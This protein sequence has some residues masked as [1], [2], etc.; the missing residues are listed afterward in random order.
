[1]LPNGLRGLRL[2]LSTLTW[3]GGAL[4]AVLVT[5]IALR[6]WIYL[7]VLGR[8]NSD[9]SVVGLMVLHAMRGDFSTFFWGSAYG[10]PQEVL[11]SVPVFAV[12]REWLPRACGSSRSR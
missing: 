2:R 9:E 10:G 8:P 4:A 3:W 5:G 1:M 6:V 11:L 7:S 12:A